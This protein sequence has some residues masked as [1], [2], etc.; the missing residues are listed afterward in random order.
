MAKTQAPRL[1]ILGGGPIGLEAALY[2]RALNFPVTVFERGRPAEHVHRWGHV[3]LFSPFG[4]NTTRLGREAIAAEN[5]GHAFP[6]DGDCLSGRDHA[7]AYLAPLAKTKPLAESMRAGTEVLRVSRRGLLKHESPGDERRGKAPFRLLLREG[8]N[9][10][11]IE[12]ADIVLDCTG[13]YA[14]HRWLG[15]GGIPA[16]GEVP[17]EGQI[18]YSVE[19]VT[20]E[21]KAAYAGK[22]TLVIGSGYS[23][24]ATICG[25]AALAEKHPDTWVVWLSRGTSTQ[26]LRRFANDP[27]RERDR[28]AARANSL[29]TRGDGC[30]E[31]H[32]QAAV[33]A[34]DSP[35]PDRGFRVTGRVAGKQRAWEV[36]RLIANVGYT[37]DTDLYRE[38]QVHECYASL[39]P[40]SLAAALLKQ[41]GGDCLTPPAAGP[42]LLRTPEPNFFILGA[43]SY[44]RNSQF[45]LRTGYDQVRDAFTLITGKAD[46][47]LYGRRR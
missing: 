45:L 20:G 3:R 29:A 37:P 26:P 30:V 35:G 12:E 41:T 1:A 16:V 32:H 42:Q 21:R 39:G 13:T 34:I 7:A 46:L 25:L 36:D 43:K 27:L 38:L 28:L 10:E 44:G 9:R 6:A 4:M 2:A 40:M 14:R 23:A 24:A 33:D 5:R 11:Q 19:D 22:T 15:D 17:L 47:D 8:K 18:A 31:F